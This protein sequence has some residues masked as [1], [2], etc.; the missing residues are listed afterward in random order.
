[1]KSLLISVLFLG[2]TIKSIAQTSYVIS[3]GNSGIRFEQFLNWQ[4]VVEKAKAERMFIFVDCFTTWCGP[5]K[6]MEK[7]VYSDEQIGKLV[8]QKFISIKVQLDST[9]NDNDFVRI[10]YDDASDFKMKYEIITVPTYLFFSPD[11]NVLH[12]GAGYLSVNEFT[13]LVNATLNPSKQYY[14]LLR[15]YQNGKKDYTLMPY[16]AKLEKSIGN[17]QVAKSIAAD[18]K[19]N[20]VEKLTDSELLKKETLD[21]FGRD[22]AFFIYEEGSKGRFFNLLFNYSKK[23]DSLEN[24]I[25]FSKFIINGIIRKEEITDKL[26]KGGKP[27]TVKPN[28]EKIKTEI[29]L[30]YDSAFANQLLP[31]EKMS[32][33]RKIGDWKTYASL[34]DKQITD[35]P[36]KYALGKTLRID[37]NSFQLGDAWA[38]NVA[39]WNVFLDC[40][41]K[42]ILLKALRW[43]NLAIELEQP[44]PN[45]QYLDTKANILYKLG[46]ISEAISCEERAIEEDRAKAKMVGK[47]Q[48][49]FLKGFTETIAKMRRGEPTWIVHE[50]K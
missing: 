49:G 10:W 25:G 34:I 47:S 30:K 18:Y 22:F 35:N 7:D 9:T 16:L 37:G 6:R 3:K 13:S 8:N 33:Y 15:E 14:T 46:K 19:K 40:L 48:G 24:Y 43:I 21:F 17:L 44:N 45:V 26:Y 23:V 20:Y 41:D 36:P 32:F 4:Q 39:A 12:R 11:G 27:L 42:Q 2:V 28:W 1:M 29:T 50:K 38:L 31:E 5:C